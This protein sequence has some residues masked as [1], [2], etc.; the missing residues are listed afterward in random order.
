MKRTPKLLSGPSLSRVAARCGM[1]PT[2]I[3][4]RVAGE[5]VTPHNRR[6]ID[7][8]LEAEGLAHLIPQE[9]AAAA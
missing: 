3:R 4:R 1:S 8:A 6:A 7:D 2:T 5:F 9:G